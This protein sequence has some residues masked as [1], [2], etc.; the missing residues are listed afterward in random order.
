MFKVGEEVIHSSYGLCK[1]AAVESI[2]TIYYGKQDCYIIYIGDTKIMVPIAYTDILR[3]PIKQEEVSK[4]LEALRNYEIFSSEAI[5]KERSK[6][7]TENFITNDILKI[8]KALRDLTFLNTISELKGPQK[9]LLKHVSKVFLDEI[10]FVQNISKHEAKKLIN[11]CLNKMKEW[12][13]YR[14]K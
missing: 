10:S 12:A 6:M 1:I 9:L 7:Y 4:V 11:H 2:D 14:K 8:T 13:K 3:Y 5:V